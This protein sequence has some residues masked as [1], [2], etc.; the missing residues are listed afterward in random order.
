MKEDVKVLSKLSNQI[1]IDALSFET[2]MSL[3][4][5]F[6]ENELFKEEQTLHQLDIASS[7]SERLYAL[8]NQGKRFS[9]QQIS[10][11]TLKRYRIKAWNLYDSLQIRNEKN[12]LRLIICCLYDEKAAEFKMYGP[13]SILETFL[14]CLSDLGEGYCQLFAQYVQHQLKYGFTE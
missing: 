9:D 11:T 7:A 2:V 8:L 3:L 6:T 12:L 14:G 5:G 10:R 1:S 13:E 4:L